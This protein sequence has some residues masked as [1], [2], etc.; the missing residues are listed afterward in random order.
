M[1]VLLLSNRLSPL[2]YKSA[3]APFKPNK[4]G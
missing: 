4:S 2:T 3:Y 1:A